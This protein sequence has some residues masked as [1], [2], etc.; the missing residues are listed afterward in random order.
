METRR[1]DVM[2]RICQFL[3]RLADLPDIIED[4][5][6]SILLLNGGHCQMCFETW[7]EIDVNFES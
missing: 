1:V 7:A 4:Y 3:G 6:G 2:S 5:R